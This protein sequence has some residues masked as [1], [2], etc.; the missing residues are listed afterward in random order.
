MG[1]KDSVKMN[2]VFLV[3]IFASLCQHFSR[4]YA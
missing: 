4:A 1:I 3:E 2:S